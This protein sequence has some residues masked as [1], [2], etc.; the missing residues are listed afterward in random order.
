MIVAKIGRWKFYTETLQLKHTE[1]GYLVDFN[2]IHTSAEMLDIIFQVWHKSW[3]APQD[4][5]DMLKA[6]DSILDPQANYCSGGDSKTVP[7]VN[8][9]VKAMLDKFGII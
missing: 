6:M 7:D 9:M 4:I 5:S 1:S 2:E 3:A 8:R